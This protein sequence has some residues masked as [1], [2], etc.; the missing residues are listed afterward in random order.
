[1]LRRIGRKIAEPIP[2]LGVSRGMRSRHS[3]VGRRGIVA[4]LTAIA[5]LNA[6]CASLISSVASDM[7]DNL[8][9][10]VLNQNDPETVRDGAPAYLLLLDSFLESNPEDPALLSSAAELYASYGYVFAGE[11][12]RARRMSS[13]AREYGFRA[14]C[15]SYRAAC[16]WRDVAYDEYAAT[17]DG[18]SSRHAD[19]VYAYAFS[20]LVWIRLHSDDFN[21]VARLPHAEAL[22][23]RYLDIGDGSDDANVYVYLGILATLLPPAYGGEPEKGRDAFERAIELS[24]GRDLSAKVEFARG[25]ARLLYERELHDQLLTEVLAADPEQPG[26]T[27]TNVL[28]QESATELLAS[29]DDYF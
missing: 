8:S 26:Y 11:P 1:M 25:Y 3:M 17:L 16:D 9:A 5:F 4:A 23:Q 12:E 6:G 24:D 7:A 10:A 28:A 19:V 15:E 20:S 27:L 14:M 13:R 2:S 18:L 21:A 29:A 22:L